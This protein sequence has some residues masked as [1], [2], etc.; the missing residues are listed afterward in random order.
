MART[1]REDGKCNA[2]QY[3]TAGESADEIVYRFIKDEVGLTFE[4]KSETASWTWQAR[5]D[6]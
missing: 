2:I 4:T 3:V 1:W 6:L 5:F